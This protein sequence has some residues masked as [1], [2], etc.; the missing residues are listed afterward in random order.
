MKSKIFVLALAAVVSVAIARAQTP[1]LPAG[2]TAVS[3][4]KPLPAFV[5]PGANQPTFNSQDLR[6]KVVVLRFWATH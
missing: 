6:G 2:L 3:P 1:K 5:L 4:A